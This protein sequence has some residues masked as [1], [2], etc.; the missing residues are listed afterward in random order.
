MST[1]TV[2][3]PAITDVTE[4]VN[5]MGRFPFEAQLTVGSFAVD[6]K[7]LMGIFTLDRE[8][9]LQLVAETTDSDAL[10]SLTQAIG[11]FLQPVSKEA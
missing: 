4:F 2:F 9:P 5:I 3:L 10:S 8:Q 6:A 7:S 1:M 11:R